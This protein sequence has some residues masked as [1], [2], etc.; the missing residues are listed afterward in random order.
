MHKVLKIVLAIVL[1]ILTVVLSIGTIK[2]SS[3]MD[4]L[5]LST[6]KMEE[7]QRKIEEAE[8]L[9][10]QQTENVYT[11]TLDNFEVMGTSMNQ[12]TKKKEQNKETDSMQEEDTEEYLCSFS[13]QRLMTEDDLEELNSKE[14]KNLP[15]NKTVVQMVINEMYAR[16]GYAFKNESIQSYFEQKTWYQ[17]IP[18]R[19]T[20]MNSIFDH[21]TEIEKENIDF[22]I[23][24]NE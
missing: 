2:T 1:G 15:E 16:Y 22:L 18:D 21:M 14:Y 17:D 7:N 23:L 6:A 8:Q 9:A 19:N 10:S 3:Q 20:D 13:S 4:S 24:H 12:T 11:K 5:E